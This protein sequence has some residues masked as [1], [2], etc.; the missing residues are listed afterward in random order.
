MA[1]TP[2]SSTTPVGEG[3]ARKSNKVTQFI[4][5]N[6]TLTAVVAAGGVYYLIKH[7]NG[8]GGGEPESVGGGEYNEE[9]AT[10]LNEMNSVNS[11]QEYNELTA[12]ERQ[13]RQEEDAAGEERQHENEERLREEEEELREREAEKKE[14]S[15]GNEKE[16]EESPGSGNTG[17]PVVGITSEH[18]ISIHGKDFAGAT[19][20]RIV[21]P[22]TTEG[23]KQYIEYVITFPGRQERWQYFTATGNWRKVNST[24]AGTGGGGGGG[25]G[26]GG[27]GNGGSGGNGQ[28]KPTTPAKKPVKVGPGI[29][30]PPAPKPAPQ[31][32]PPRAPS[33]DP[34][35]VGNILHA[36][37][38]VQRLQGEIDSLNNAINAHPNAKEKQGWINNRNGKQNERD[39]WQGTVDRGRQQ[40]GCGNV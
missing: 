23:N 33:C 10:P 40:P 36:R 3:G 20:S 32:A 22:G 9:G 6:K 37:G 28:T 21:G 11:R 13:R 34:G 17:E 12:E 26:T 5:K 19:S 35:T 4:K 2:T 8:S 7:G 31:P 16:P 25:T 38:E 14:E 24:G 29:A 39:N 1:D 18:G 27:S 15:K 30:L